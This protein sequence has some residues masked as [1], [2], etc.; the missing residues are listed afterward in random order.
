MT[1]SLLEIRGTRKSKYAKDMPAK[2]L[3]GL[4]TGDKKKWYNRE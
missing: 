4:E 3:S 2:M 1:Q